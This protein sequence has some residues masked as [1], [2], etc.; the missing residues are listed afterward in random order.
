MP[1]WLQFLV[2]MGAAK[3]LI[4]THP[5]VWEIGELAGAFVLTGVIWMVIN[6]TKTQRSEVSYQDQDGADC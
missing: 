3:A 4:P 5:A 6:A 1:K 2:I